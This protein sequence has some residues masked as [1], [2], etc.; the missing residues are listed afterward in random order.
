MDKIH[1][2]SPGGLANLKAELEDR[3]TNQRRSITEKIS[4]AKDQGDLSE[5][6]EYSSAKEM[7][8][9]NETRIVELEEMIKNGVVVE[10]IKGGATVSMGMP[11]SVRMPDGKTKTFTIVGSTETDPMSGKISNESPLGHAF[12]GQGIGE[13]VAL[14]DLTYK[15]ISIE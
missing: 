13:K 9:M 7:Q 12:L 1:Y 11:F 3:R 2:L 14:G 4:V 5:N 6:F 10:G 15:I 8:A